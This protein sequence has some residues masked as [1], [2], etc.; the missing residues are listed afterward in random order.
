MDSACNFVFN[1]CVSKLAQMICVENILSPDLGRVLF[2]AALFYP[3]YC[4]FET[5][6]ELLAKLQ[7][8]L[9][10]VSLHANCNLLKLLL[11]PNC[12]IMMGD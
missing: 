2:L 5:L 12:T 4:N 6:Y 1:A 8:I 10:F 9:V 11:N 3:Q 7:I